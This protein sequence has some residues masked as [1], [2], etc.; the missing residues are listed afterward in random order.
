MACGK[1]LQGHAILLMTH[2]VDCFSQLDQIIYIHD[3][4]VSVGKHED[5]LKKNAVY[6]D[7]IEGGAATCVISLKRS[8]M[9]IPRASSPWSCS[10]S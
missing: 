8:F 6:A 3:H 9:T 7:L 1:S 4:Q 10:S 2:W 5:L